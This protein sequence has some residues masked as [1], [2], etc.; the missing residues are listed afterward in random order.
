M[1]D[2][3]SLAC[4]ALLVFQSGKYPFAEFV[5]YLTLLSIAIL[6]SCR[7]REIPVL[8]EDQRPR[9]WKEKNLGNKRCAKV[10]IALRRHSRLG[11]NSN[12]CHPHI[13]LRVLDLESA[14]KSKFTIT[15]YV[16]V[17]SREQNQRLTK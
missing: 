7:R 2:I 10:M 9:K 6:L 17:L 11:F 5:F 1:A 8:K 12:C 3:V 4:V 14:L 15:Y 13:R 16:T